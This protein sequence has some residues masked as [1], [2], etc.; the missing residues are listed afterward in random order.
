[1]P[2]EFRAVFED[3]S[4]PLLLTGSLLLCG[5]VYARG[6]LAIRKTRASQFPIWRLGAFFLGLVT[7]GIAIASPLD[8]FADVSLSAHMVEHLLLMSF[9]P[10]LLLLGNPI[11][12]TLRGLPQ[13]VMVR[14]FGPLM[15]SRL[16][17]DLGHLLISPLVAWLAM[18]LAFLGWHVPAAYDFALDNEHW[19]EVEHL[20]FVGT[21]ILFWWPLIRPW[22]MRQ[23]YSRWLLL[24]YLVMADIVNTALSAFLAFCDR[25]VY[26]YY[27]RTPNP[28]HISPLSDQRA[29]AVVMW[30]I[31][32]LIFL[33]PAV[34]ITFGLLRHNKQ[35]VFASSN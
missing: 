32:S 16:L 15:R 22:P 29:G 7:I 20:C 26:A 8:G 3:W 11:V 27:L 25:P 23:N 5:I 6:F 34:F 10:P 12:P 13:S 19:H 4:P 24:F 14:L 1:M 33:V 2:P 30:V 21:S 31:G 9:A 28:F 18:N 17:R 35:S